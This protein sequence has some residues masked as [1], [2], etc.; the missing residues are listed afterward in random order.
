MKHYGAIV[1]LQVVVDLITCFLIAAGARRLHSE[2]AAKAA[3]V[4]AALCPF[5]ANY[6]ATP[7]PETFAI[8]SAALALF[9]AVRA[10]QKIRAAPPWD[11]AHSFAIADWIGCGLAIAL[12]IYLRP[13]DGILLAAVGLCLLWLAISKREAGYLWTAALLGMVSLLPLLPWTLRNW[14]TLHQIQP[15]APFYAEMP[16][17]YVPQGFIH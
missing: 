13:D 5:T 12:G 7:L 11:V 2:R 9:F 16:G 1:R 8:F 14:R 17:E 3:F 10:T 4:L 15:L 6:A